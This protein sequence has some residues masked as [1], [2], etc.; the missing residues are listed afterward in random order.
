MGGNGWWHGGYGL[1]YGVMMIPWSLV[2]LW[3][4]VW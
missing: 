2:G 1:E 4:T 3:S